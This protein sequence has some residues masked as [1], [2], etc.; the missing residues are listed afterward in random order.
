MVAAVAMPPIFK[1]FA[2]TISSCTTKAAC[3][4]LRAMMA[5]ASTKKPT[6]PL[7]RAV[8]AALAA[9]VRLEWGA[10]DALSFQDITAPLQIKR[11][12]SYWLATTAITRFF[13]NVIGVLLRARPF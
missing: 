4:V 12:Q 3:R 7:S 2:R 13:Q 10:S 9:T 6:P 1:P 11:Y 8:V 5:A